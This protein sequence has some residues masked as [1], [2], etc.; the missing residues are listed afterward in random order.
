[1]APKGVVYRPAASEECRI[2]LAEPRGVVADTGEAGGDH[3][4]PNDV[5]E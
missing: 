2:V 1:V 5:W 3:A 4:A